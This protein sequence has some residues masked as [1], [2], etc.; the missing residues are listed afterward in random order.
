MLCNATALLHKEPPGEKKRVKRGW[1][2]TDNGQQL[3]LIGGE[4]GDNQ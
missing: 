3:L 2:V 4:A 1:D